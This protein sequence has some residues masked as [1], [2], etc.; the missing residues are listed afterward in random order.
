MI[1]AHYEK[2]P[3]STGG[4]MGRGDEI[5]VDPRLGLEKRRITALH[6]VLETRCPTIPHEQIDIICIDQADVLYQLGLW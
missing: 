6:E 2:L 5:I 4:G 1:Q 3:K